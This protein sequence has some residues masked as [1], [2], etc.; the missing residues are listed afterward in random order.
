MI[1]RARDMRPNTPYRVTH[2][3]LDGTLAIGDIV[4]MSENEDINVAG[5]YGGFLCKD[6]WKHNPYINGF[7]VEPAEDYEV[8]VSGN[9]ESLVKKTV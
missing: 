6:E 1:I 9:R 8:I 2:G 3:T 4:W 5:K 7:Y